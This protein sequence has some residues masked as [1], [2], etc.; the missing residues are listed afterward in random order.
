[1]V[2]RSD[3]Y[4]PGV[5]SEW[6]QVA[7]NPDGQKILVIW[8][9]DTNNDTPKELKIISQNNVEGEIS[10]V[11][12]KILYGSDTDTASFS[13]VENTFSLRISDD[14]TQEFDQE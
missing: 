4:R 1:M 3:G 6:I 7:F 10:A 9:W 13:I 12:G 11:T 2:F 5:A 8:H 14:Q